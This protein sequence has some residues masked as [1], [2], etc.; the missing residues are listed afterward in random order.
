[1]CGAPT[2]YACK[3]AAPQNDTKKVACER[4]P[5]VR[6]SLFLLQ[7]LNAVGVDTGWQSP[8][9]G[10]PHTQPITIFRPPIPW[11]PRFLADSVTVKGTRMFCMV[12]LFCCRSRSIQHNARPYGKCSLLLLACFH[13]SRTH[14]P[15]THALITDRLAVHQVVK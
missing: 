7:T 15:C 3:R 12:Q 8:L 13:V 1:M 6:Q 2:F 10:H 5:H 14:V 11:Y 4:R 9:A